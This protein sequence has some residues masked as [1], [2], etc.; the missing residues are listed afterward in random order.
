[1][2][3]FTCGVNCKEKDRVDLDKVYL[4]FATVTCYETTENNCT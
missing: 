4:S 2:M 3:A 1:M